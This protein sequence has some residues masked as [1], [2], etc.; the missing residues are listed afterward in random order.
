MGET[1]PFQGPMF[2]EWQQAEADAKFIRDQVKVYAQLLYN[3]GQFAL[4]SFSISVEV[5]LRYD[6]G[7]RYLKPIAALLGFGWIYLIYIA[8]GDYQDGAKAL[9]YFGYTFLA[10]GALHIVWIQVRNQLGQK[11]HSKSSGVPW[12]PL[13]WIAPSR[14][15]LFLLIEP[16]IV[17]TVG[18]FAV[19][20]GQQLLGQY[21]LV[22]ACALFGKCLIERSH[23]RQ[24][25]LDA[26]DSQ[27]ESEMF[28]EALK[29]KASPRKAKGFVVPGAGKWLHTRQDRM[30]TP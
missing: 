1:D 27:I 24:K 4:L 6:F 7:E 25:L 14:G 16:G 17:I 19:A 8:Y 26:I 13:T 11:W 15:S 10:V 5:F 30:A 2:K 18:L 28:T 23:H 21:L 29:G 22:A 12:A 9:L 20:S 3:I